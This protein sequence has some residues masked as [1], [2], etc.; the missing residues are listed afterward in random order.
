M[1]CPASV[2]V[3]IERPLHM[4]SKSRSALLV[5]L[6]G[7]F[8]HTQVIVFVGCVGISELCMFVV[9]PIIFV[10]DFQRL[11]RDGFMPI[12]ALIFMC[13]LGGTFASW[14]NGTDQIIAIKGIAPLYTIFSVVVV[15]HRLLRNN[16]DSLKWFVVGHALSLIVYTFAFHPAANVVG[17]ILNQE[18]DQLMSGGYFWTTRVRALAMAVLVYFYL[19]MPHAVS[20]I[21]PLVVAGVC[22]Y[23]SSSGRS[24]CLY[25]AVA[26]VIIFLGGK[27]RNSIGR[28]GKHIFLVG[29]VMLVAMFLV[30]RVYKYTASSGY[31]G[32]AALMKYEEHTSVGD[33]ALNIVM[34]GRQE[35]FTALYA[36]WDNPIIGYGPHPYDRGGYYER[37]L[38]KYGTAKNY[39]IYMSLLTRN[40]VKNVIPTHSHIMAFWVW[41]GIFGL[42]FWMYVLKLMFRY[43]RNYASAIP[44]WFVYFAYCI[45]NLLWDMFFSPFGWRVY[46][47]VIITCLVLV[48]AVYE[49]RIRLPLEMEL[50]AL[51]FE[52]RKNNWR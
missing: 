52:R 1:M 34:S 36:V 51:R 35:F 13:V 28:I 3:I 30:E 48:K 20:A 33:S 46:S 15:M 32:D 45:P 26:G 8:S 12:I 19:R 50:E 16:L 11:V 7:L 18:V 41:Y 5:F 25:T 2:G 10:M 17:E 31:L 47:S 49:R 29:F 14:Y 40:S 38:E 9:A 23:I 4:N 6:V 44:Q 27:T 24:Q 21:A 37:F 22:L 42:V 43:F 39:N